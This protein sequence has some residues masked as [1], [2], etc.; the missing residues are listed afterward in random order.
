MTTFDGLLRELEAAGLWR[1][2]PGGCQIVSSTLT[3]E[4]N[5]VWFGGGLWRADGEDLADGDVEMW[6]TEMTGALAEC[7]VR[8]EV[9]TVRRPLEERSTGYTVRVNGQDIVL[10][11]FDPE[12]RDLPA[13]EDPW[14]DCTIMPATAI[15]RLLEAAGSDCRLALFW[16]GSNDGISV[17][18]PKAVLAA[19]D[20]H[21]HDVAPVIP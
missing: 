8:L 11:D 10:Y 21:S 18:A 17:L 20:T 12:E 4:D 15:N 7:G 19:M 13:T 16:P 9:A 2:I 3:T 5:A 6:L 14:T 1:G